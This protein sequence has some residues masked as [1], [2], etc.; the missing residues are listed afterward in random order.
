MCVPRACVRVRAC[1]CERVCVR[2]CVSVRARACVCLMYARRHLCVH[3]CHVSGFF[4]SLSGVNII[5]LGVSVCARECYSVCVC[6]H[7][8]VGLRACVEGCVRV[9]SID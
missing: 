9:Y 4:L 8:R 3:E 5:A 7:A 1:V 6:A 2:A